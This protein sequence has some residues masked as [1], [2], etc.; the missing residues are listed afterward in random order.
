MAASATKME[1]LPSVAAFGDYGA[2]GPGFDNALPTRTYGISLRVPV[3]DG[4]RRDARRAESAS[5]YRSEKV[6]TNDLKEQ[7]DLDVR[8][9]LDGEE[10]RG[11]GHRRRL[12]AEQDLKHAAGLGTHRCFAQC[13]VWLLRYPAPVPLGVVDRWERGQDRRYAVHARAFSPRPR[14]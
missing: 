5:Q 4:G 9:A 13:C 10:P 6:R 3:F 7:I 2:I 12:R 14:T 11:A 1:R 8:L